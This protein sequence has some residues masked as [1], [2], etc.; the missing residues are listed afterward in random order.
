MYLFGRLIELVV[1]NDFAILQNWFWIFFGKIWIFSSFF[2]PAKIHPIL[3]NYQFNKKRSC[4]LK[5]GC[6]SLNVGVI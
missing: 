5:K 2:F 3:H 6:A 4:I 1:P